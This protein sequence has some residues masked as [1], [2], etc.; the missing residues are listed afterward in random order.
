MNFTLVER[1]QLLLALVLA[2][3]V[4]VPGLA[5]AVLVLARLAATRHRTPVAPG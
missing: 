4:T 1:L 5:V 3:T 2:L